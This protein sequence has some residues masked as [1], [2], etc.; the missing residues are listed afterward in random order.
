M[1]PRFLNLMEKHV[2]GC[3]YVRPEQTSRPGSSCGGEG[4]DTKSITNNTNAKKMIKIFRSDGVTKVYNRPMH[5]S[6]L[7]MELPTHKVCRSDSLYIGQKI[8]ALPLDDQL[9]SGHNYFLLPDHFFQSPLSFLT[10][11][12]FI[13]GTHYPP[14]QSQTQHPS[15]ISHSEHQKA[16]LRKAENCQPFHIHKSPSGCARLRISEEFVCQLLMLRQGNKARSGEDDD[17]QQQE[18][19]LGPAQKSTI[20]ATSTN[21]CEGTSIVCTTPQLQKEY[22][23][24]VRSSRLPWKPKLETIMESTEKRK[25]VASFGIRRRIRN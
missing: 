6:E 18:D 15:N 13:S 7:M 2:S 19:N 3:M 23:Q 5:V 12:S 21:I 14:N 24:L 1:T 22:T 20:T 9:E 8:T 17:Q 25:K 10:I 4:R 16:F 11:A